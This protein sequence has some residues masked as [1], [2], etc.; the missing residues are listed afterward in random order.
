MIFEV[1]NGATKKSINTHI[2]TNLTGPH[3]SCWRQLTRD[4]SQDQSH[5]HEVHF[6]N[7]LLL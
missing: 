2:N 1:A 5:F 6:V 3:G 7:Y 4:A